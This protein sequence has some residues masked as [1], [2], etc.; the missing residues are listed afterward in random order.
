MTV[1]D[2]FQAY[3]MEYLNKYADTIPVNHRK[4]IHSIMD[5]RTERM[6]TILCSCTSCGY[7]FEIYKSCGNRHCPTCQREKANDWLSKRLDQMLPVHHF[8][9]T[10]TVPAPFREFFRSHQS[11]SYSNLF[12]SSSFVLKKLASEKTYF[13]GDIP[14]FFGVLHTWGRQLQYH[15][16]IHYIIPGGAFSSLDYSFHSSNKSFYLPVKIMSK[17]VKAYFYKKM[18]KAGFLHLIPDNAWKQD[19]NV[20]SLPVGNGARSVQYLA[21]YVFRTAISDTRI[22]TVENDKVLFRYLDTRTGKEKTIRLHVFEFIR[23]FCPQ[24]L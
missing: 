12:K 22:L 11:F 18:E 19:W 23:R 24:V 3:G 15:P 14:G 6:G 10:F 20:N 2:I 16:H 9:I 13:D 8:M 5:C 4:V 7:S 1:R 21:N 17:L